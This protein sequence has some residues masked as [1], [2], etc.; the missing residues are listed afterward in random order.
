MGNPTKRGQKG[1]QNGEKN[2]GNRNELGANEVAK[3]GVQN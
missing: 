2:W 1:G 3:E